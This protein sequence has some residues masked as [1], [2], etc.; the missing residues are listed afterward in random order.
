VYAQKYCIID[1]KYI[2]EKLDEYKDAQTK[3]LAKKA[4]ESRYRMLPYN[5]T[6][7]YQNATK[8]WPLMRP[9]YMEFPKADWS[10]EQT[11]IYMWG[12]AV[13]VHAITDP[14]NSFKENTVR[15]KLPTGTPWFDFS[16]GQLIEKTVDSG[17]DSQFIEVETP[18]S[19]DQIP[20]FVR[21]GS[22]VPMA[23]VCQSTDA[24]KDTT[25]TVH[26]YHHA[27]VQSASGEWYEDDGLTA[28]A[29][30]MTRY[31]RLQFSAKADAKTLE[32]T[33]VSTFGP[34]MPEKQ[35]QYQVQIH[36]VSA[37]KKV[38]LNGKSCATQYDASQQVLILTAP[39]KHSETQFSQTIMVTW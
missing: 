11:E 30:Q 10:F 8:G 2:L 4:I 25:V 13:L 17:A 29:W 38:K 20:V 24:Y 1:S 31:K 26:Y 23:T 27:T 28:M 12:D 21:A 7:A 9:I 15:T 3:A 32:L 35:F 36:C 6:L 5:Y 22:F 34:R 16:S 37:P 33:A 39:I 18:L 19:L 14:I